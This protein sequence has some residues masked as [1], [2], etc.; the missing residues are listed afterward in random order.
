MKE[1]ALFAGWKPPISSQTGCWFCLFTCALFVVVVLLLGS[2]QTGSS[3]LNTIF[4]DR[5]AHAAPGLNHGHLFMDAWGL[6]VQVL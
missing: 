4:Q 2:I 5:I 1:D 3:T 6:H